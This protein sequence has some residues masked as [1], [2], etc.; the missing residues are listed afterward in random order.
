MQKNSKNTEKEYYTV[1]IE[2]L[3][4]AELEYKVLASSPEEALEEAFKNKSK[5]YQ[6]PKFNFLALRPRTCKVSKFK[7]LILEFIRRF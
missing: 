5:F 7:S 4:P 2:A 1:K 3:I 6:A